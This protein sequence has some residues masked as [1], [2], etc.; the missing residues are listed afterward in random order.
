MG[1][2]VAFI[3]LVILIYKKFP[4]TVAAIICAGIMALLSGMDV[5]TTLTG[6]YMAATVA[7]IKNYFI[8]FLVSAIFGRIMDT[9][10]AAY[11]IGKWLGSKLGA[12]YAIWGVSFAACVLT[13]GGVS[14]FVLVFAMYPIALVLFQEADI[15]RRLIPGALAA[16]AF[17]APNILW[18]SPGLCNVIPTT[19]LGTTVRSG[20]LVSVIC[21]IFFYVASNLYMVWENKQCHKK[22]EGFVPTDKIKKLLEENA[23]KKAI[24][25]IIAIIPIVVMIVAL[26]GFKLDVNLAMLCGVVAAYI[27][28]WN[29]IDNKLDTLIVGAQNSI[30]SIMNTSSAVGI[31]GVAKI[32]STFNA[33]INW[34]S[35]FSGSPLISWAAAVMVI[36]GATGSGSGGVALACS[37]LGEHYLA[38]GVDPAILHKIASCAC[39]VLDSMP[40]N[41]VMI[42]TM[43]A[44]DLTHKESYKHLFV[45]T[46]VLAFVNLC[47]CVL[48]GLILY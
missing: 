38:T 21:S 31:G 18:G 8:L 32:T 7:F 36:S 28:F 42:T 5:M 43:Q 37:T 30:G 19:Y 46:V 14:C 23:N 45:I 10:G 17:T 12:R 35:S 20:A 27:L 26:N 2:L 22:G 33:L 25:P 44:C 29:R 3:L 16:G 1:V 41:G 11:S 48:L 34:V 24:K 13:Y 6:D 40:W 9:S 47:L 4:I 39:I 15:S